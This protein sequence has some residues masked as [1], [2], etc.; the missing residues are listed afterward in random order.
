MKNTLQ[1][2]FLALFFTVF[3]SSTS[4]A[5]TFPSE[6]INTAENFTEMLDNGNFEAAYLSTATLFKA[7]NT[8]SEWID[9]ISPTRDLFGKTLQRK[10]KAVKKTS[11]YSRLPDGTY[12]MVYFETKL[13]NKK[14][15]AE[16]VLICEEN[17]NWR[18]CLYSLK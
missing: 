7:L 16:I 13:E 10:I 4:L 6:A 8:E 17:N 11:E 15:A 12:I 3:V 5:E 14:K 18:P 9:S 1:L 2:A